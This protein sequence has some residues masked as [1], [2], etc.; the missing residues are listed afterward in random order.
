M[1]TKR[2]LLDV[3]R[4]QTLLKQVP[5]FKG[6]QSSGRGRHSRQSLQQWGK[7]ESKHQYEVPQVEGASDIRLNLSWAL[8]GSCEKPSLR[9]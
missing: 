6:S 9:K 2:L 3:M 7:F 1:D 4:I 5:G 8:S